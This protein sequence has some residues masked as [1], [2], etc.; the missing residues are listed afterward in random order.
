[1]TIRFHEGSFEGEVS[2]LPEQFVRLPSDSAV[3]GVWFGDFAYETGGSST[4]RII[5]AQIG[6]SIVPPGSLLTLKGDDQPQCVVGEA[7]HLRGPGHVQ[8]A[9]WKKG[10]RGRVLSLAPSALERMFHQPLSKIRIH[11]TTCDLAERIGVHHLLTALVAESA[12]SSRPDP[13]IVESIA[14]AATRSSG[15]V[16]SEPAARKRPTLSVQ[17][18]TRLRDIIA[19]QLAEPIGLRDLAA[20]IGFSESYL[21]RSFK[22][23][24]GVTPYQYILRE[25]VARAQSLMRDGNLSMSEVAARSGFAN[26]VRMRRTFRQVTGRPPTGRAYAAKSKSRSSF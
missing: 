18:A 17:Q 14:V 24:F 16:V 20:A 6:V 3:H 12:S 13:I 21:V 26:P 19:A 9:H 11:G 2:A 10:L 23:S 25:R 15:I 5:G 1:M 7:F 8:C 22:G 4:Y